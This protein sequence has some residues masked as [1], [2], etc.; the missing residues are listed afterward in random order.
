[1]AEAMALRTMIALRHGY[2][3]AEPSYSEREIL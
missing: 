1:M 3:W 2:T